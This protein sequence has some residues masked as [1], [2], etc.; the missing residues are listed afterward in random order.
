MTRRLGDALVWLA[1]G[2]AAFL[3]VQALSGCGG[4]LGAHA[5]A[6]SVLTVAIQGAD[7]LA[8]TGAEAA[9]MG[10]SDSAC[11][12]AVVAATE[13]I[14]AGIG[15]AVLVASAYVQAVQLAVAGGESPD[16]LSALVA[17][18]LRAL[19]AWDELVPLYLPLGVELPRLPE[20]LRALVGLLAGPA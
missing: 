7:Q 6:A 16:V 4:A 9:L 1:L 8:D 15:S 11:E 17:V 20:S 12:D 3:A 13:A 5:R 2:A 18:L 19:A 10:C 14:D